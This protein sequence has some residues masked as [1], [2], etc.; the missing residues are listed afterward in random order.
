MKQYILSLM[1]SIFS[2]QAMEQQQPSKQ[3][4]NFLLDSKFRIQEYSVE[5]MKYPM[6]PAQFIG[7]SFFHIVPLPE[8]EKAY[9]MEIFKIVVEKSSTIKFPYI[10]NDQTFYATITLLNK[11]SC[12]YDYFVKIKPLQK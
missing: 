2:I 3:R 6:E 1:I 5:N 12:A 11:P 8:R 4:V 9:V 7:K 10:L